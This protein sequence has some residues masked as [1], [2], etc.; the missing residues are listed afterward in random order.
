MAKRRAE[1]EE[2]LDMEAE[3]EKNARE[4]GSKEGDGD[5]KTAVENADENEIGENEMSEGN[6]LHSL[7]YVSTGDV[8]MKE[9]DLGLQDEGLDEG[10]IE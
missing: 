10:E 2:E 3:S 4:S 7:S 9:T 1:I 8:E 6:N 5:G